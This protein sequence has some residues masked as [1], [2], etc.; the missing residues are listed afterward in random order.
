MNQSGPLR[1]VPKRKSY[2]TSRRS[3]GTNSDSYPDREAPIRQLIEHACNEGDEAS[4]TLCVSAP[5]GN[6]QNCPAGS[7]L[8]KVEQALARFIF[9]FSFHCAGTGSSEAINIVRRLFC[10]L[11][12]S[13]GQPVDP[14]DSTAGPSSRT[15]SQIKNARYLKENCHRDRCG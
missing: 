4:T 13:N 8:S 6:R 15:S 2:G 12:Q 10:E 3:N 1:I 5:A 11:G 7:F 9:V 14:P